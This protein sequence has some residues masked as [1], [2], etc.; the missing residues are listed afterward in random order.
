M[1]GQAFQRIVVRWVLGRHEDD[2]NDEA[3]EGAFKSGM[4][5][6]FISDAFA[7]LSDDR[8]NVGGF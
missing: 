8:W 1:C 4:A 6:K 2:D 5:E 7:C 3:S